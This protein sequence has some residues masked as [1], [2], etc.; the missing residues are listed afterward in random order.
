MQYA[1]IVHQRERKRIIQELSYVL[2]AF[3]AMRLVPDCGL[4]IF[5]GSDDMF[6]VFDESSPGESSLLGVVRE[7]EVEHG[8]ELGLDV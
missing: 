6:T 8:S 5:Q 1:Y 2:K 7:E 4:P 3:A